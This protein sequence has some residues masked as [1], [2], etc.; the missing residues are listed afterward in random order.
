MKKT[1]TQKDLVKYL[2]AYILNLEADITIGSA[3]LDQ[4]TPV[5]STS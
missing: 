5:F 1:Y 2:D 4:A 3:F